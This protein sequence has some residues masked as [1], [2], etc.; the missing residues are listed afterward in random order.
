[1]DSGGFTEAITAL[2]GALDDLGSPS[3][4][5]SDAELRAQ[6]LDLCGE[7]ARL[8]ARRLAWIDALDARPEAVPGAAAGR[9]AVT[10]LIHAARSGRAA[11]FRDVRAAAAVA[12]DGPLPLLGA[13]LTAGEVSRAHVDMAA[14]ALNDIPKRLLRAVDDDGV[15]GADRVDAYLAEHC[16]RFAPDD[17]RVLVAHL[18]NVLNPD[19]RDR[20]DPDA[21]Q[22]RELRTH[23][24]CTGMLLGSFQLDPEGGATLRAAIDHHAAPNPTRRV[25]D[26]D[27]H[28]VELRDVR[29]Q[30]QRDADALIA[31]CAA[32]LAATQPAATQPAETQPAETQ[33]AREQPTREQP[34]EEQ[35]GAGGEQPAEDQPGGDQ[36]GGDQPGGEQP[37]GEQPGGEQPGGEQP[38]G[39]QPG[40]RQPA[41]GQ[42]VGSQ[43]VGEQGPAQP[44]PPARMPAHITVIA[45][46][47][48]LAAA[49]AGGPPA[50]LATCDQLGPIPAPVLARLACDGILRRVLTAPTGAVL[51]VGRA[52]RCATPTQRKALA[53]RDGWCLVPAC[54]VPVA[55]CDIHHLI[56]WMHGGPT[57][58][59]NLAP[60]CPRHHS[61][62]HAGVWTLQRR[63]DLPWA[64][65]P[66]WVDPHRRPLRNQLPAAI[67]TTLALGRQLTALEHGP[68]N[69][70]TDATPQDPDPP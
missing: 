70:G 28:P 50:G 39:E 30:P 54:R 9:V 5:T 20:Y 64:I 11:A 37:G 26:P 45:T 63:G 18:L 53:V 3:L 49:L 57:D 40:G 41:Q 21:F 68:D 35:P 59:P 17:V 14:R 15:T 12:Q 8:E 65:P 33:P 13:A 42:P 27:G 55:R 61:A 38:G 56:S 43:P 1:M 47:E 16:R 46:A 66:A 31:I 4:T 34:G 67:Q 52:V 22:R 29:T 24:D 23:R 7:V 32:A 10:F 60:L 48:Q 2:R 51:D 36:P 6:V 25:L 19:G 62:V 44:Q 58:L 69:T